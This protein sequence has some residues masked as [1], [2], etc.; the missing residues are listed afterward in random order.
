MLSAIGFQGPML[1]HFSGHTKLFEAFC[2]KLARLLLP[3]TSNFVQYF[4]S[5]A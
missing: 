4:P 2:N 1:Y 3:N 5:D